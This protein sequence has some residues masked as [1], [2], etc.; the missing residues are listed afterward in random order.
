MEP[1]TLLNDAGHA[2]IRIETEYADIVHDRLIAEGVDCATT[3]KGMIYI[4]PSFDLRDSLNNQSHAGA[5]PR[6]SGHARPAC[7]L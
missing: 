6:Q 2:A 4:S 3:S 1:S 7:R 5:Q